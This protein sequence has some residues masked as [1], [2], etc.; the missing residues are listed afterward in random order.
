MENVLDRAIIFAT[1]A[2]EGQYRKETKFPYI[3]HPL[4]AAAIVGTKTIRKY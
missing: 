2:H 4:E 3:L 1:K